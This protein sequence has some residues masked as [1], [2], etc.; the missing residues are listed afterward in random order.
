MP[1]TF[2]YIDGFNLYYRALKGSPHRWL[3][4]A[5]LADAVPPAGHTAE[6]I[7]Y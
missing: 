3:N 2:V 1:R 5:A 6:A 7:K 4:L